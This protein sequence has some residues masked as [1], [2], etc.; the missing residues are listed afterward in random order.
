MRTKIGA[1]ESG[2]NL[3]EE[4]KGNHSYNINND[5]KGRVGGAVNE[6]I[7]GDETHIVNGKFKSVVQNAISFQ[8]LTS[9]MKLNA[10]TDFSVTT[11]SGIVGLKSGS[12]LNLKSATAMTVKSETTI[13]TD[14]TNGITIDGSTINLNSGTK[15]AARLDDTVDT[16]DDPAGISGSDGS[17]KIETASTTVI[18]GD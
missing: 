9:E 3:E 8:S 10:K 15:G 5:I 2:G 17:N 11:V 6:T 1:G 7:E 13:D 16:G 4:I 18:I 14:A 12:T